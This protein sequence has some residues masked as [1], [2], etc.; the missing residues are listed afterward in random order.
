MKT[1][2]IDICLGEMWLAND[3]G[4]RSSN[5]GLIIITGIISRGHAKEHFLRQQNKDDHEIF[6][7]F[8]ID[9]IAPRLHRNLKDSK[10][11]DLYDFKEKPEMVK[12]A[13]LECGGHTF[14]FEGP[15]SLHRVES[16]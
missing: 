3:K 13:G 5:P 11:F 9:V 1:I 15:D 4:M 16:D 2:G 10:F 6:N 14:I 8:F 7:I 12:V